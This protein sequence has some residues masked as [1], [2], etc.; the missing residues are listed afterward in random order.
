MLKLSAKY[1][2]SGCAA[3][4]DVC[5]AHCIEYKHDASGFTYPVID[6]KR[7]INCGACERV[8][9]I[10]P[11]NISVHEPETCYAGWTKNETIHRASSSGGLGYILAEAIIDRGGIV[12]GCSAE[13]PLHI[14][15][16]RVEDKSDLAKLQGSKYVQSD[17]R[18]IYQQLKAD[19][20]SGKDV[21]FIGTP[22]QAS[23]V[24][25]LFKKS[26][27]NLLIVNLI[28]HGVPSQKMLNA[29]I[30]SIS[31]EKPESIS[32]REGTEYRLKLTFAD[33]SVFSFPVWCSP[34]FRIFLSGYSYRPSCYKCPY[35]G[36]KRTG[37]V[38]I[39]DFWGIKNPEAL[40]EQARNGISVILVS[41]PKGQN[42][43]DSISSMLDMQS[44]P[45][46]E[47]VDGN[48]Q[49]QH[50]V[51]DT[52]R[53]KLFRALYPALPLRL[54]ATACV[55]DKKFVTLLHIIARKFKA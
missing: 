48:D 21:L 15:H 16:I 26:P 32:F 43:L 36:A 44:R 27:D 22:C 40:P 4:A 42:L 8:C 31:D 41:T 2:C 24:N 12:Y 52:V 28:C 23:A 35:A 7:C 50:P 47:A 5:P 53:S 55:A 9:P 54:A 51:K 17:T 38:T 39:G 18:G 6:A 13:N 11:E 20:R 1:Q 19:V 49:L 3:C 46:K 45:V 37:D 10:K 14:C 29:Q 33:E 34:Y 25:N 30:E